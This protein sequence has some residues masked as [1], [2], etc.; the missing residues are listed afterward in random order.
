[1][2]TSGGSSSKTVKQTYIVERCDSEFDNA[3]TELVTTREGECTISRLQPG[4]SYRFRVYSKNIN[5]VAGAPS[6]PVIVH[7][8]LETPPVPT[9]TKTKAKSVTLTWKGHNDSASTRD[10]RVVNK[11]FGE[12]TGG[13]AGEE[14][15]VS[16]ENAFAR[17]D[18]DTSGTIDAHELS[19]ILDDLGVEVTEERLHEAFSVLDRNGDG[20]I[21]F[22]EFSDWWAKDDVLY[23]IK[24]SDPILPILSS[25]AD[26]APAA[27][28]ATAMSVAKSGSV[29]I[30]ASNKKGVKNVPMPI[31]CYRGSGKKCEIAGLEPNTLYHFKQRYVGSRSDSQLS[32]PLVLMTA[33]TA[34]SKPILIR[35]TPQ[36]A[37]V[38]WYPSPGGA[39]KYEVQAMWDAGESTSAGKSWTTLFS[40]PEN[41]W[42]CTT[43]TPSTAYK[44]RVLALNEQ[45]ASSESSEILEFTTLARS[46]NKP[47]L[48]Q[49]NADSTFTIECTGDLAVGDTV[50]ITERLYAKANAADSGAGATGMRQSTK[51]G[52]GRLDMSVLS[53]ASAATAGGEPA[54]GAY[55]GERT[56][57]AH[58][59]RDN[60]RSGRQ[61]MA[62]GVGTAKFAK[63]RRLGLEVVWQRASNDACKPYEV[64]PGQVI[65]RLQNH[66]EQFEVFRTAWIHESSRKSLVAEFELLE[67]CYIAN[68]N[69]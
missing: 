52:T 43:L 4:K 60:F 31:V 19:Y 25:L 55:I 49:R 64:K 2:K 38:K 26:A 61:L 59:V 9:A 18:R 34:V 14:G 50:L 22:E 7:T 33:P 44:V 48:T 1:M 11:I 58:I 41:A 30:A 6:D 13:G 36:M 20:V 16:I 67:D 54:V 28:S 53:I 56:I 27:S 68:P 66:L 47:Q 65:E 62:S 42:K 17:Y 39:F 51:R 57:A 69:L 21:S 45:G 32:S 3:Y 12:W 29:A 5:G 37:W 24:R 63:A 40:S 8:L 15:A 46:D 23:T 10:P 35:V